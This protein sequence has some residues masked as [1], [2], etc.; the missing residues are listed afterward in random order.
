MNI[1]KSFLILFVALLSACSS[2]VLTL[3]SNPP[4]AQVVLKNSGVSVITDQ[5]ITLE[6]SVFPDGA[7]QV[8]E[9]LIFE[10]EG[11]RTVEFEKRL[12]KGKENVIGIDFEEINTFLKIDSSPVSIRIKFEGA[13]LP[14]DWPEEFTT[15]IK[16]ACTDKEARSLKGLR[17]FV[18]DDNGYLPVG[19]YRGLFSPDG[20]SL[21]LKPDFS[22][23]LNIPLKPVVTTLQV[24]TT[25]AGA[26]IEDISSGGFGYIGESPVIRNF[27]WEDVVQ[28]SEKRKFAN[29]AA[30]SDRDRKR[31]S[32]SYIYLDLRITKPGFEEAYL[33]RLRLPIGEERSFHKNLTERISNISFASDPAGVHV[34]V[35]RAREKEIYDQKT[36]QF[37]TVNVDY[38]K[39]LGT[40]PFTLN[41]D[42]N[43]PLKHGEIFLFKKTGYKDD[44]MRFAEG[45]D[46][47]YQ[48]MKPENI[49]ER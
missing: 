31:L 16:L 7:D 38:N 17:L 1:L 36:G 47:Y 23:E 10:K 40:T 34:Y 29:N 24:A 14:K 37:D 45:N 5:K 44:F 4:G 3:K 28:W 41:I 42:P 2:T 39:H 33:R 49:K 46:Q 48:V 11:Y 13:G 35:Q 12:F 27:N 20:Y 9:K 15:P 26:I 21:K 19:E 18:D 32:R 30:E 43:D 8:L 25:P 6:S 22:N